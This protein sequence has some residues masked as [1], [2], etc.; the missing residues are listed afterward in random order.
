MIVSIL[1]SADP[2]ENVDCRGFASRI[3]RGNVQILDVRTSEEFSS[4]HI[5]GAICI[6][7]SDPEFEDK[8]MSRLNS[9]KKVAVYCRSGRRSRVAAARLEALGFIV[10][11]LDSGITSWT[12]EGRKTVR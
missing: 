3:S 9:R 10:F 4:G 2:F 6:S 7:V 5:E 8:A 11:N 1:A 12:E